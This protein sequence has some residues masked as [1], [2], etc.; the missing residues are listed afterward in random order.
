MLIAQEEERFSLREEVVG[1]SPTKH[2][3]NQVLCLMGLTS[4]FFMR[5][6]SDVSCKILDSYLG[7]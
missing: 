4:G 5:F 3:M 6:P 1:S 2:P 7:S